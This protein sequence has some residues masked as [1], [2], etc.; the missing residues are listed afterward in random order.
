M[1][2]AET[3][4]RARELEEAARRTSRASRTATLDLGLALLAA[5]LR[6]IVAVSEG[7]PELVLNRDRADA[8]EA[9]AGRVE[10]RRARRAA[11]LAMDTRRRLRVNVNETLALEALTFRTEFLLASQAE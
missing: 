1:A 7:A 9:L 2:A 3:R 11:E 10:S 6:D 8:V 5:W 4:R